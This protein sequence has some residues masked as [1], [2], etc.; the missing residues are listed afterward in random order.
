MTPHTKEV[1]L[2]SLTNLSDTFRV[3]SVMTE[4]DLFAG[5]HYTLV[6][7]WDQTPAA[8]SNHPRRES[9]EELEAEALSLP[10]FMAHLSIDP[11][12]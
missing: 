6:T 3:N 2:E 10:L 12:H 9:E 1:L 5:P 7:E 8:K 4:P 11:H